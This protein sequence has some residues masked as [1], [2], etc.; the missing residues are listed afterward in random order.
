MR[1]LLVILTF[2]L[3]FTYTN[4]H[5]DND[6]T[7]EQIAQ[8]KNILITGIAKNDPEKEAK[9]DLILN[10]LMYAEK[11]G[12]QKVLKVG[13]DFLED[14]KS[15]MNFV[16]EGSFKKALAGTVVTYISKKSVEYNEQA[17]KDLAVSLLKGTPSYDRMLA[18]SSE[19]SADQI[20]GIWMKYIIQNFSYLEFFYKQAPGIARNIAEAMVA[21]NGLFS[22]MM[23]KANSLPPE[24]KKLKE[25]YYVSLLTLNEVILSD[26]KTQRAGEYK[27]FEI[28]EV[29]QELRMLAE[30]EETKGAEFRYP[31]FKARAEDMIFKT[32]EGF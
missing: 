2:A 28:P 10:Y 31:L 6:P 29:C 17:F 27:G 30:Y 15:S 14:Y 32:I 7:A 23:N 4:V 18:K 26:A 1:T 5:A 3:F 11:I 20:A 22:Y 8:A 25:A 9:I 21:E 13:T 19:L 12:D 24:S 16:Q